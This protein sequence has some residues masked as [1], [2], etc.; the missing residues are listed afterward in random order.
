MK[1]LFAQPVYGLSGKILLLFFLALSYSLFSKIIAQPTVAW[2]KT[3]GGSNVD[4]AK[5]L[6]PTSDGGFIA[7]GISYSGAGG[8]KSQVGRGNADYWVV[9]MRADGTREWDKTFGASG[10]DYL[11][12]VKQTS[13]GGYILGGW[14]QS[15]AGGDKTDNDRGAAASTRGD[16]WLVKLNAGG[17]KQWDKTLGGTSAE[18]LKSVIQTSDGGY[19]VGGVSDS[20]AGSDK[21][22]PRLGTV[23]M[24]D[25]WIVKLAANG[26][27]VWDKTLGTADWDELGG[28]DLNQEG[29]YTL[30]GT[31]I[32]SGSPNR[33]WQI[34]KLN[35]TGAVQSQQSLTRSTNGTISEIHNTADN[36]YIVGVK[37]EPLSLGYQ[38]VK[39]DAA[40]NPV[41]EKFFRGVNNQGTANS[42]E[43]TSIVQTPDG[44]YLLGGDTFS[45]AGRDKSE[46]SRGQE[47]YW[48]VKLAPDGSKQWDKTLGGSRLDVANAVTTLADGGYIAAGY[49]FSGS[50]NEKSENARGESD[51]WIVKLDPNANKPALSFSASQ[52]NFTVTQGGSTQPKTLLLAAIPGQPPVTLS[53]T[54]NSNWLVLPTPS[55]GALSFGINTAG[56]APGVYTSE[57]TASAAGYTSTRLSVSLTVLNT[58]M[59]T[60]VRIN[61]GGNAFT[62]SDGRAFSSDMYFG[63]INRVHSIPSGDIKGTVD[64]ELYRTERSSTGFTYNIPVKNGDYMVVLHFAEIWFGAPGGRPLG[65]RQRLFNIDLE[66]T[67]IFTEF[68]VVARAGAPM[69]MTRE[70]FPATISDGVMNFN[71]SKGSADLPTLAAIEV[72]PL[73]EF[74][75]A[76]ELPVLADATVRD[77]SFAD[78]NAGSAPLLDVKN[79]AEDGITRYTYLQFSTQAFN[80]IYEARLRIYGNNVEA[81]A[82][83]NLSVYGVDNDAWTESGITWNNA[84]IGTAAADGY[85]NVNN[86][87]GYYEVDVTRYVRSQSATDRLVSLVLK[88]PTAK[89]RKLAFHSKENPSGN[90]PKLIVVTREGFSDTHRKGAA[91][92]IVAKAAPL[93][94]GSVIFP[95]PVSG[96]FNIHVSASHHGKISL[97]T[98]SDLGVDTAIRF[99]EVGTSASP[100]EISVAN[101]KLG[102]GLYLL[103][104]QSESF[105]EVLKMVVVE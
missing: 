87:L 86:T 39:L 11:V 99:E 91:E 3:F 94:G 63:G 6:S 84:P 37:T 26:S 32:G 68:N 35:T 82:S 9:K 104:I 19:I 90:A 56:L 29:G 53:K 55:P 27:K 100:N 14:S 8:D 18:I 95:N 45:D 31:N 77:G 105:T 17:V 57:V 51:F 98:V 22:N 93:E 70:I 47:D 76:V 23:N 69:K 10:F 13:D 102:A 65:Q 43:L 85:V 15:D 46:D 60:T 21:T 5:A 83:V 48:L 12:T 58:T 78:Q 40:G 38:A 92:E 80:D 49:S 64:D 81:N 79:G 2:D 16:Y 74:S 44:G 88:N 75:G 7:G 28:L 97:A 101:Q 89:N 61:A 1:T 96:S 103:K 41:W 42:E 33:K 62:T 52:L 66:G 20:P 54:A 25:Y 50:E 4:E 36:G 34:I 71:F 67:R 72:I 73:S 24:Q 30:I 59:G